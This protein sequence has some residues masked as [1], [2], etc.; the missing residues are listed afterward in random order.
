MSDE[1][2]I[3]EISIKAGNELNQELLDSI[4]QGGEFT[5]EFK[6][7]KYKIRKPSFS[8]KQKLYKEKVK[9]F[10]ELI[11]DKSLILEADLK[12]I[13]KE[14]GIDI[15]EYQN[16]IVNL[17][18]EKKAYQLKLGAVL[19]GD[20]VE[21]DA[22]MYKEQIQEIINK[23]TDLSMKKTSYLEPCLEQQ[24]IVYLYAYLTT[25]IADKRVGESWEKVWNSYEEFENTSD[26]EV[27]NKIVFYSAL[28]MRDEIKL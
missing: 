20:G 3:Q 8:D 13:Y 12:A 5:F 17:E 2:T 4:L 1:K 21:S 24:L 15:D 22:D 14:R 7:V 18:Q 19:A 26:E 25:L 16:K 11:K 9:K 23:Q 6:D 10:T 27:V 28:M